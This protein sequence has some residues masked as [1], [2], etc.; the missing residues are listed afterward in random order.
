MTPSLIRRR[1]RWYSPL[2]IVRSIWLRP[3]VYTAC[4]AGLLAFFLLPGDLKLSLREAIAWNIAGGIYLVLAISLMLRQN[5]ETI[6]RHAGRQDDS[7]LLILIFI[8]VAIASSFAAIA[9]LLSDAKEATSVV[10]VEHALFAGLTIIMSWT[11]TQVV[12]AIHYAHQYYRPEGSQSDAPNGLRFPDTPDPDYWDFLYF[13]ISFGA[14][15]QTADVEIRSRALRRLV[16]LH[17]VVSFFFNTMV[18]ALT[19]NLGASLIG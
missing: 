1:H 13:S 11:V 16:T 4:V 5:I 17:A 8:L 15:S 12:F 7:G 6:R 2:S 9:G 19:I 3:R 10:K 14:A 18:L